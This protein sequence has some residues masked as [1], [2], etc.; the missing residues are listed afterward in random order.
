MTYNF[1]AKFLVCCR[2]RPRQ[3][4]PVPIGDA[5]VRRA[6]LELLTDV[7]LKYVQKEQEPL[8]LYYSLASVLH[9]LGWRRAA[10]DIRKL[11]LDSQHLPGKNQIGTLLLH[12]QATVPQFGRPVKYNKATSSR[13]TR[14]LDLEDLMRTKTARPL[15]I[16]PL[17]CDGQ[18]SHAVCVIDDLLFDSTQKRA[19]K[20]VMD[21][22]HWSC[23]RCGFEGVWEAYRL[24]PYGCKEEKRHPVSHF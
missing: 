14:V 24:T 11:G 19:M 7:T 2:M 23:G 17:A 5:T 12:L 15:V 3:W 20:F 18:V 6:P 13:G 9:Y 4:I 8:C 22:L 10:K 21:S 1:D 16:I